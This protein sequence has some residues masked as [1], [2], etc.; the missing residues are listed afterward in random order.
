M[1]FLAANLTSSGFIVFLP[2]CTDRSTACLA[3][4]SATSSSTFLNSSAA[5]PLTRSAPDFFITR[6]IAARPNS[7]P[8][9]MQ[10]P[11]RHHVK[12][13]FSVRRLSKILL[14]DAHIHLTD[15][16][17]SGYVEHVIASLRA[18]KIVA[19]SVT[20]DIVTALRSFSLFNPHRDAVR[21]FVG[22]HPE[23]AAREDLE[24]FKDIV[25]A[26]LQSI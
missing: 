6:Y 19:C 22:I 20:V 8:E 13:L 2:A 7:G 14:F 15:N 18:M 17:Y 24:K 3:I 23:A 12:S 1:T 5:S 25:S 26:N 21:Q 4:L 10:L 11:A 16:E 9:D